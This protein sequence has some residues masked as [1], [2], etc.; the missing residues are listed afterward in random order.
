MA[1]R[2]AQP[3][4]GKIVAKPKTALSREGVRALIRRMAIKHHRSLES[5]AAY[6]RGEIERPRA[7]RSSKA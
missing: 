4:G 6:D 1:V 2:I 3:A 7:H 5:L